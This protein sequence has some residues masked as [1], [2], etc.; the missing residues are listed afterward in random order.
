MNKM[1][2][3]EAEAATEDS[4]ATT[5]VETAPKKSRRRLIVMASIPLLIA[6]VGLFLWLTSGDSV[7]TDNA[8]VK[9]DVTAISTQVNG[10]VSAVYV[11]ENQH[12]NRGDILYR[13]DPAPYEAALDAAEAQLAA[14][15]LSTTQLVVQAQGTGADIR[16]SEANLSIARRAF[17]RQAALMKRG[18][19]TRAD[20]D[21]ALNEVTKAETQL[22]DARARANN[23]SA[24]IAPAGNQPAIAAALAAVEKARLDLDHTTIRAPSSGRVAKSDRLLVGQSAISG[25]A[26]LSIVGDRAPWVEANFKEGDLARMTVGQRATV[27]FDAYPDLELKGRVASIG[28]GTGSE[29]S[30]LP[31]Q[32]AN[33]NWVKVTQRVPVRIAFDRKPPR[34]MI[35]GLSSDV[36]IDLESGR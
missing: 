19:T 2:S 10:P 33:G 8:Y 35:A 34:E 21:D 9:Q 23:A 16:G 28:S 25:V 14:A 17:D 5:I 22:A 1:T 20:Y 12:V 36:E 26:M 13:I 3:V 18:F 24:A 31:A 29:F 6:A 11:D 15:R 32:N 7:S 4:G 30:V 27:S